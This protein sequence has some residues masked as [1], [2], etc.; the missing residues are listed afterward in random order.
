VERRWISGGK[1]VDKRW[2]RWISGGK[3]VEDGGGCGKAVIKR[4]ISGCGVQSPSSVLVG[5]MP[6]L[7]HLNESSRDYKPTRSSALSLAI[8][9]LD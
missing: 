5:L 2:K 6:L 9:I 7:Y 3:A 8:S 1:A 4:W